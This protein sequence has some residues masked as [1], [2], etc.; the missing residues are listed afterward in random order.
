MDPRHGSLLTHAWN[1]DVAQ[2][3]L[4]A[5]IPDIE[6]ARAR[7][8]ALLINRHIRDVHGDICAIGRR[9]KDGSLEHFI[10]TAEY[11]RGRARVIIDD[12]GIIVSFEGYG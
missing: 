3:P 5:E 6:A 2:A 4:P 7:G 10:G 8:G 9:H 12:D 11:R 1:C